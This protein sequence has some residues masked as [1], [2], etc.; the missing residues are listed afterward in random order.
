MMNYYKYH[1]LF[2]HLILGLLVG[3]GLLLSSGVRGQTVNL[4]GSVYADV[5]S[6]CS[7][8]P[9][10]FGLDS[11]EV[12]LLDNS[13]NKIDSAVTNASGDYTIQVDTSVYSTVQVQFLDTGNFR[14]TCQSPTQT[15]SNPG[16]QP[17]DFGLNRPSSNY[18]SR[19]YLDSLSGGGNCNTPNQTN[20]FTL[21]I[22]QS[23]PTVSYKV[24][25]DDGNGYTTSGLT[26]SDTIVI[27]NSFSS[28]GTYDV[29]VYLDSFGT[30]ADKVQTTVNVTNNCDSIGGR[31]YIDTTNDCT[32]QSS[33]QGLGQ[34]TVQLRDA[35]TD[36]LIGV[37]RTNAQG[38]YDFKV[39]SGQNYDVV[40]ND[41][42]QLT[43]RCASNATRTVTNLPGKNVNFGLRCDGSD[44]GANISGV[45]FGNFRVGQAR[46]LNF[47]IQT[48]D[49]CNTD[50]LESVKVILDSS[51]TTS[52]SRYPSSPSYPEFTSLS[53]DTVKYNLKQTTASDFNSVKLP[54][55]TK[56]SAQFGTK[57][58]VTLKLQAA[59]D[60][61][62]GNNSETLCRTVTNSYDPN[63]KR[64]SPIGTTDSGFIQD[65][66]P[67]NYTIN[68][69]NNGNDTAFNVTITDTLDTDLDPATVTVLDS[70]DAYSLSVNNR[71]LTFNFNNINLPDSGTN[72][73]GSQ[74]FI[75]FE[76]APKSGA[77]PGTKFTNY[78]DITFD[79]NPPIRTDTALNTLCRPIRDTITPSVCDQ[80][81]YMG[82]D[83]TD[84]FSDTTFTDTLTATNGC[85]S[86]LRVELD[87]LEKKQDFVSD[88]GG[89]S[90]TVPSGDTTLTREPTGP[91]ADTLTASNGCDSIVFISLTL[92]NQT[93]DTLSVT[94]CSQYTVPSGDTTV[95]NSGTYQDTVRSPSCDTFL[96]INV[97]IQDFA[98]DTF[99]TTTCD[100]YTVPSGDSTYT[101]SGQYNDT[102]ATPSGCDTVFTI[103]LNIPEITDTI[104]RTVCDSFV[105]P[106]GDETYSASGL[107]PDTFTAANGCDSIVSY[108][109]T[110]NQSKTA[111]T[112]VSACNSYTVPSG[113]TTY[114]STGTY[115]DTLSTVN[116]CDSVISIDLTIR[117]FAYDTLSAAFCGSYTVPSGD[118]TYASEGAYNDTVPGSGGCDTVLTINLREEVTETVT[119]SA[120]NSFT[121]PSGDETYSMSGTYRDTLVNARGCDS[122]ITFN[123][124]VNQ[125]KTSTANVTACTEY[126]VP[127]GDETYTSSGS[128][129]DTI[130]T[131]DGCDSVITINL[132]ISGGKANTI[133][134][135]VCDQYTVPSGDE[136]YSA[137]GS[138]QD[139]LRTVNGCDS[140]L[141]I[142]LT[143][144]E[145]F[146]DT[147]DVTTC[148]SYTVP[149]GDETYNTSGTYQDTVPTSAG[150]D[151]VLVIN[152]NI[153]GSLNVSLSQT[154]RRTIRANVPTGNYQ[155]LICDTTGGYQPI[156]GSSGQTF[157]AFRSASY[158]VAV[159]Q[160]GGC[161]DT[162]ACFSIQNVGL[163]DRTQQSGLSV[164]PNPAND[165]L[166]IEI[167]RDAERLE[168]LTITGRQVRDR[169]VFS[170]QGVQTLDVADLA[171][172]VYMIKLYD[173]DGIR[174]QKV[175][176]Q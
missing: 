84:Y 123:L 164:Y 24:N 105:V 168:L 134:R 132:T 41:T 65:P 61:N 107:Y 40:F 7:E 90:Y 72:F 104:A 42:S 54:I 85:D 39:V 158:A 45:E 171:E 136:T 59:G 31:A 113:D 101:S 83:T 71:V 163:E 73:S 174:T 6:N 126:T 148:N 91:Y 87:I 51:L 82:S 92:T 74:G 86:F 26:S 2:K 32:Y 60:S 140:V 128:Y 76:V 102:L 62:P 38:Q 66:Q 28:T 99:S 161:R 106:T 57:R 167:S 16:S 44:F 17:I 10:D 23:A 111:N 70:S 146:T 170:Q 22:P 159:D 19:I 138:Y 103:N 95:A 150:C 18:A 147:L 12:Y 52:R 63:N 144:N 143:I 21:I 142:N 69:Q 166:R 89:C 67:L 46:D 55:Y 4:T 108:N 124:T 47:S 5:D 109:V 56:N 175:V 78:A 88:T 96:T 49:V 81:T 77:T 137:N 20:Y 13:S 48:F 53:G 30:A 25:F 157:R 152:L 64:V 162:S 110:I 35:S 149:S 133:S 130:P 122:V 127:S 3:T 15:A 119:R 115:Q 145:S 68:F 117:D 141:T 36:T 176:I 118:E 27:S 43:H 9:V 75:E 94:S 14:H 135:T 58:C 98:Y 155:W 172:G 129:Q 37:T 100:P 50:T 93:K 34:R 112:T 121:V 11:V 173:G 156:D 114:T 33:E 131:V 139:T 165:E 29:T 125:R 151:S 116:G 153:G 97:S 120:C 79:A 1:Q 169:Q 8:D 80:Y 154:G 160:G